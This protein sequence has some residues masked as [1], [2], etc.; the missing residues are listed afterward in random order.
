LS[1]LHLDLVWGFEDG[2]HAWWDGHQWHEEV[3]FDI[4]PG[5]A[6]VGIHESERIDYFYSSPSNALIHRQYDPSREWWSDEQTLGQLKAPIG[7]LTAAC[8]PPDLRVFYVRLDGK[9]AYRAGQGRHVG[10]RASQHPRDRCRGRGAGGDCL[11]AVP[12]RPHLRQHARHSLA[13]LAVD[14]L[15]AEDSFNWKTSSSYEK[16]QVTW[17]GSA[18][19]QR[20]AAVGGDRNSGFMTSFGEI[21]QDHTLAGGTIRSTMAL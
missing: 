1:P 14:H 8:A 7:G 4:P 9:V 6:S 3:P 19:G 20:A 18:C 16:P 5:G 13:Y 11:A 21:R 2:R 17:S 12:F 10:R 15:T